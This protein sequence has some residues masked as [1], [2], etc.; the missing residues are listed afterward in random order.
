MHVVLRLRKF[1]ARRPAS[2]F[3]R[4]ASWACS[5]RPL[6]LTAPYP[7]CPSS[8]LTIALGAG[9]SRSSQTTS[10]LHRIG[11]LIAH[12]KTPQALSNNRVA[13]RRQ[14]RSY[15]STSSRMVTTKI[16]GA[17]IAKNIREK[18]NAQIKSTQESNPRFKP[19]LKII[20]G[21]QCSSRAGDTIHANSPLYQSV[22]GRIRVCLP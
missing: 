3:T 6:R 14:E 22:T 16:D 4:L 1:P 17:A 11:G 13:P 21:K 5:T 15:S 10:L 2:S 19:S 20:Q 8:C 18:L 12:A 9:S 7:A